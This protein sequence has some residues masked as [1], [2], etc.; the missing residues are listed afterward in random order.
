MNLYLR[1][2]EAHGRRWAVLRLHGFAG[3]AEIDH[4]LHGTDE[5]RHLATMLG[6]SCLDIEAMRDHVLIYDG[7]LHAR[8]A[9]GGL[10]ITA[11]LHVASGHAQVQMPAGARVSQLCIA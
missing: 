5:W 6:A 4:Q 9:S 8:I 3:H 10:R 11:L 7:Q 1:S 2:G